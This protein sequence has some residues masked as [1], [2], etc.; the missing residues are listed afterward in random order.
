L[1]VY[2]RRDPEDVNPRNVLPA[3][4]RSLQSITQADLKAAYTHFR[5]AEFNEASAKFRLILQSLLLVV[6]KDEA[7]QN[8][9]WRT[10]FDG[11]VLCFAY[12]LS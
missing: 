10:T 8:E 2:L 6:T 12:S 1:E 3:I 9:V 7:E 4:A 11:E 5:K